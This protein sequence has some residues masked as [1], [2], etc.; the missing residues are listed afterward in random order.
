MAMIPAQASLVELS[1]TTVHLNAKTLAPC[2]HALM[3]S[4]ER[5]WDVDLFFGPLDIDHINTLDTTLDR[6]MN[7]GWFIIQPFSRGILWLLKSL[8]GFGINYGIILILFAF[9]VRVITGPL[10]KKSF[11]ST[12][13][14]KPYKPN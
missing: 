12:Q 4:N 6:I 2:Y 7:F 13:K 3:Q 14:C 1:G 11:K 9:L 5:V 8:H 10:T